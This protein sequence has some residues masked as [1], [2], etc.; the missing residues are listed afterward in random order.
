MLSGP[1]RS[2]NVSAKRVRSATV[3]WAGCADRSRAST[4]RSGQAVGDEAIECASPRFLVA[5]VGRGRLPGFAPDVHVATQTISELSDLPNFSHD[6][7]YA[8]GV[9]RSSECRMIDIQII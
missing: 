2:T 4:R 3:I 9:S 7:D 6:H 1:S 8:T 5:V